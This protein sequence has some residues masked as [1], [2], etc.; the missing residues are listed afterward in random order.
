ME[1]SSRPTKRLAST[2]DEHGALSK[3]LQPC[4]NNT[5][6]NMYPLALAPSVIEIRAF[7]LEDR[8]EAVISRDE[9]NWTLANLTKWRHDIFEKVVNNPGNQQS[10]QLSSKLSSKEYL[11]QR[12]RAYR[13]QC[14]ASYGKHK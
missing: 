1:T 7:G 13:H 14:L 5:T 12:Q 10:T 3:K 6:T 8:A 4:R 11:R 9:E 2:L